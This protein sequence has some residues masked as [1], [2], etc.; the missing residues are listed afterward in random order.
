MSKKK[1]L[2]VDDDHD[3]VDAVQAVVEDGGYDVEVAYDG[4]QALEKVKARVDQRSPK[5]KIVSIN[6]WNEWTESSYLEPDT[7][8]GMGYLDAIK[9]VFGS[10]KSKV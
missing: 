8:Y 7:V 3:F 5:H 1:I 2:I 9:D 10:K 6:A 4:K